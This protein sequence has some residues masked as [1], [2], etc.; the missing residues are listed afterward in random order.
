MT[1]NQKTRIFLIILVGIA[2]LTSC[3][4]RSSQLASK[5]SVAPERYKTGAQRNEKLQQ[6]V[7]VANSGPFTPTWESFTA[8]QIPAWYQD[9]KFGIFI[10][11]GVYSVPAHN[12]EWYPRNMYLPNSEEFTYHKEN[13][14]EQEAFG[15]K[16]F[17]PQFKAEKFNADEWLKVVK[18]SGAKY[19]VPVAEHHD[20]F[21]LY[22]NSYSRWD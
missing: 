13:F 21:S 6:I 2:G 19:I 1:A 4:E 3:S 20:G 7:Q 11:W 15:Y 22:D 9:A 14:G 16:D 17:V 10:H 8:Y 18:N 5:T 12:G